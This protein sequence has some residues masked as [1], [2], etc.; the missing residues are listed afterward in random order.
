MES[1][2]TKQQLL[3]VLTENAVVLKHTRTPAVSPLLVNAPEGQGEAGVEPRAACST[4]SVQHCL[5]LGSRW[6]YRGQ[7][8]DKSQSGIWYRA[9]LKSFVT[10]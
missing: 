1:P 6:L 4:R 8:K 10:S 2:T 5:A 3:V 7:G 9:I